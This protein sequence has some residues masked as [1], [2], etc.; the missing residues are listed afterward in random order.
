MR[1]ILNISFIFA[2]DS[3]LVRTMLP[4]NVDVVNLRSFIF[5]FLLVLFFCLFSCFVPWN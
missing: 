5:L 4:D 2:S 3:E 1:Q